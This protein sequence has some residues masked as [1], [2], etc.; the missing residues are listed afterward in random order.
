MSKVIRGGTIVTA[1]GSQV[2][3]VLV[4]GE[5]IAAI[6][7]GLKGD[8]EVDASGAYVMPGGIDPH[9]HLEMPFMGT[10]SADDFYTGTVAAA[11]CARDS[12]PADTNRYPSPAIRSPR[13]DRS[14]SRTGRAAPRPLSARSQPERG[15]GRDRRRRAS[16][17]RRST[18][19]GDGLDRAQ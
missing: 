8:E 11:D 9:V 12:A 7:P 6:G 10:A 17:L 5:K 16:G 19:H 13:P 1:E 14:G 4:E 2:A 15:R 3:D 18:N